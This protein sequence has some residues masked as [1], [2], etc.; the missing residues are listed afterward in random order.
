MKI[1]VTLACVITFS[2]GFS[3]WLGP[4]YL[5]LSLAI[6]AV[7]LWFAVDDQIDDRLDREAMEMERSADRGERSTESTVR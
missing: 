7:Q 5:T 1:V 2:A 3:A 4:W 6:C